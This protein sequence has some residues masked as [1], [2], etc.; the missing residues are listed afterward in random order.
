MQEGNDVCEEV[1]GEEEPSEEDAASEG[2]GNDNEVNNAIATIEI[3]LVS[4]SSSKMEQ[5]GLGITVHGVYNK[6]SDS[7]PIRFGSTAAGGWVITWWVVG[8]RQVLS[9]QV[10]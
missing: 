3:S 8:Y 7:D 6:Q 10:L 9:R 2:A 4:S 5:E 1:E